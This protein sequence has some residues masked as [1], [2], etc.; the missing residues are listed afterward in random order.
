MEQVQQ[1]QLGRVTLNLTLRGSDLRNSNF[2]LP[3][4]LLMKT[5]NPQ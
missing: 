5:P 2:S 3:V 1:R 4:E